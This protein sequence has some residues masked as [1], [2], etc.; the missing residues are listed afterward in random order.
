MIVDDNAQVLRSMQ[1]LLDGWECRTV[2]AASIEEALT[3]LINDDLVPEL[4]LVDYH[5]GGGCNGLDGI[6][7]IGAEFAEPIPAIVISSDTAPGLTRHL[8]EHGIPFLTK[9]LDVARLR[10]LMQHLLR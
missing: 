7:E 1:R 9:P 5:L 2:A 8:R 3:M 4:I 10:A 6:A